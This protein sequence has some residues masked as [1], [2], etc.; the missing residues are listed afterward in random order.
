MPID[1]LSDTLPAGPLK[2]AALEG[3]REFASVVD[4]Y[5][6]DMRRKSPLARATNIPLKGYCADSYLI[7]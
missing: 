7:D 3:C 4:R 2:I 5:L 1:I 6:V